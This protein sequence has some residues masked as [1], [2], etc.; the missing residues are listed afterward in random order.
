MHTVATYQDQR[1][2]NFLHFG[3]GTELV[4]EPAIWIAYQYLG[5]SYVLSHATS[6]VLKINE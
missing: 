4:L 2:Y 1:F 3:K 6:H 5:Q